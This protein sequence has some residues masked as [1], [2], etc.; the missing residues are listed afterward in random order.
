ML[1]GRWEQGNQHQKRLK[2]KRESG[3]LCFALSAT[4][5]QLECIAN[6]RDQKECTV[7]SAVCRLSNGIFSLYNLHL[8]LIVGACYWDQSGKEWS[9]AINPPVATMKQGDVNCLTHF[10]QSGSY[11]MLNPSHHQS[12]LLSSSSVPAAPFLPLS[13][14]TAFP[15]GRW[16]IMP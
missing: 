1:Q 10:Q 9:L 12:S 4:N 2:W 3:A 11:Y 5:G 16:L 15:S 7:S 14:R 6:L 8:E 13:T